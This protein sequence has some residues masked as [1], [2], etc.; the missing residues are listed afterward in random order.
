MTQKCSKKLEFQARNLYIVLRVKH[1]AH[2]RLPHSAI[3]RSPGLLPMLYA[4]SEIAAALGVPERTL[5]DWLEAGAPHD[6]DQH[7][8]IWIHGR[9]FA[10]WITAMREPVKRQKLK[11][12][13]AYCMRCNRAVQMTDVSTKAMQGKLILIR[14]TC[15]NCGCTINRG[16]RLPT[17]PLNQRTTKEINHEQ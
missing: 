15:P 4:V 14:G 9:K 8:R 2:I 3:V 11:D 10:G 6:R 17:Y 13:E 5:R 1:M 7:A 12:D 16:G